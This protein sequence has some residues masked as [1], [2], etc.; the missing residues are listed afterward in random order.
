MG[1]V[2]AFY[3]CTVYFT[4]DPLFFET[5]INTYVFIGSTFTFNKLR[6]VNTKY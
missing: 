3:T 4:F 6:D 5:V 1:R 2:I